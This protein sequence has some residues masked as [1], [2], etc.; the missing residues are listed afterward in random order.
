MSF[1]TIPERIKSLKDTIAEYES[2]IEDL[3][4]DI[5]ITKNQIKQLESNPWPP[6]EFEPLYLTGVNQDDLIYNLLTLKAQRQDNLN[7]LKQLYE[8][9]LLEFKH[10][11]NPEIIELLKTNF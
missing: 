4:D 5:T 1:E 6:F 10:R 9:D 8:W 11:I 2:D 3:Q 7:A